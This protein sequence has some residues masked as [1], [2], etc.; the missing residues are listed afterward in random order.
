MLEFVQRIL[1]TTDSKAGY[2][3]RLFKKQTN[4][5]KGKF[6]IILFLIYLAR[7]AIALNQVLNMENQSRCWFLLKLQLDFLL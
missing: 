5:K 2:A 7:Y 1:W 6:R 4:K 3:R